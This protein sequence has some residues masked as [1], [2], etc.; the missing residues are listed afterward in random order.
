MRGEGGK[1]WVE[2][3]NI[4]SLRVKTQCLCCLRISH[5]AKL[6]M[7]SSSTLCLQERIDQRDENRIDK[8]GEK[9]D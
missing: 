3:G 9:Q 1:E 8:G 7:P 2:T 6:C 5:L 4:F